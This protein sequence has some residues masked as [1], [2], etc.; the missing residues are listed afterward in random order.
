M[1]KKLHA[2]LFIMVSVYASNG[3]TFNNTYTI[4]DL[5]ATKGTN[6]FTFFNFTTGTEVAVA[7]S[8]TAAWDI[9][10]SGTTI[11]FNGGVKGPSTVA[12]QYVTPS[13]F[14]AITKA[15]ET[16]YTLTIL[17]G[18]GSWYTYYPGADFSG[19]HTIL[20]IEGKMIVAKLANGRYVKLQILNYYQGA[21][22]DVPTT[23]APYAG[24]GKYYSFKY[25]ISN[26]A[27]ELNTTYAAS[28]FAA[29]RGTGKFTYF[30]FTTGEE[31]A[32]EDSATT[33]WD[34][35]FS[36][37]TVIFNG[38]TKGPGSVAAQYVTSTY[39][40]VTE[41]P[42]SGY[43][44]NVVSGSG[45]WY[46]Y[47]PGAANEGPHTI[48][49]IEN[50]I[51]VAKLSATKY[52]KVQILSYYQGAPTNVPTTGADYTGV[53]KYYAFRYT[54]MDVVAEEIATGVLTA[55]TKTISI[56]PNPISSTSADLT[57]GSEIS[58][59]TVKIMD[60]VGNQ[61]YTGSVTHSNMQLTNLNLT[62]GIYVVVLESDGMVYQQK[63]VV[64]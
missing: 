8:A 24:V 34:I 29:T 49:P 42:A 54:L 23:G 22:T 52:V 45:S 63:L 50:K 60:L 25:E 36:G 55:A 61:V 3:Q 44:L 53:G 46:T 13:T 41:V 18:S 32:V 43:A 30:N 37:T 57:I 35:G 33:K 10:F 17:G 47:Y 11:I 40:D 16:G 7:D 27:A 26:A 51:I 48:V 15:P 21:P 58:A 59:G 64:K 4:S 5:A 62:Q 6:K 28:D 14:D 9:A 1:K 2:I 39:D 20:P 12:A 19:P 31:V 38:G 56:Y